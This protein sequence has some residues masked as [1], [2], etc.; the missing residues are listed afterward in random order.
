MLL[1]LVGTTG[2]VHADEQQITKEVTITINDAF[3]PAT[4]DHGAD[5][6]IVL[7]GFFPNSCYRWSKA[8]VSDIRPMFHQVRAIATVSINRMCLMML[9]PFNKEVN[10]GKLAP[11]EHTLRFISGDDTFFERTMVVQ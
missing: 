3:V 11:G 2:T 4:V 5:A 1:A 10:L 7:I 9:V 8:E 6:K